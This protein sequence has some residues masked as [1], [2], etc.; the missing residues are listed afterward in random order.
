MSRQGIAEIASAPAA[1]AEWVI[2]ALV[3]A[4]FTSSAGSL[5]FG[6]LL[7]GIAADLGVGVAHLGQIPALS[8]AIGAALVLAIGPMAD[9]PINNARLIAARIYRTR[10]DLFEKWYEKNGSDIAT[11]VAAM[12]SLM[13]GVPGDSAYTRLEASVP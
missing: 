1:R 10:L 7:P 8:A 11:A 2:P 4:T 12:D 9:R 6:A 3:V 13:N 5:A